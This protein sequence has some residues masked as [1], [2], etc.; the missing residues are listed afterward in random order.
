MNK[1]I[2]FILSALSCAPLPCKGGLGIHYD[3]WTEIVYYVIPNSPADKIGIVPGDMLL[4]PWVFSGEV[5]KQVKVQWVRNN[6]MLSSETRL[7]CLEEMRRW[8]QDF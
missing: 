7:G 1:L 4:T 3:E 8:K 6:Q 2:L 5:G